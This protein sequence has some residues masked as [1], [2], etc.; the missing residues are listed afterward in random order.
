M[1]DLKGLERWITVLL[2]GI[3]RPALRGRKDPTE[4]SQSGEF[5]DPQNP[6]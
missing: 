1:E 4:K 5:E 3:L 6:E 2:H